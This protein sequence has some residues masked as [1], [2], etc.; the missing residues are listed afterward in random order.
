MVSFSSVKYY[1]C[2]RAKL[3][4]PIQHDW[5]V[6]EGDSEALRD[7]CQCKRVSLSIKSY[8]DSRIRF[9]FADFPI[10]PESYDTCFEEVSPASALSLAPVT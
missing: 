10:L 7:Y 2:F 6:Q 4:F 5:I 3:R 8:A 1:L 9:H